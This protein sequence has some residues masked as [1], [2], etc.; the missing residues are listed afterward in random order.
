[1][2]HN[3]RCHRPSRTN[4]V[5][6]LYHAGLA[7]TVVLVLV[8]VFSGSAAALDINDTDSLDYWS[9]TTLDFRVETD[10]TIRAQNILDMNGNDI[11]GAGVVEGATR[12]QL[13]G[14][15]NIVSDGSFETGGMSYWTNTGSISTSQVLNGSYSL[16]IPSKSSGNSHNDVYQERPDGAAQ[17]I[18]VKPGET[19]A[20]QGYVYSTAGA[21]AADIGIR[22]YDGSRS[23]VTWTGVTSNSETGSW[24]FTRGYWTVPSGSQYARI[25][26]R[27]DD[28]NTG[29]ENYFDNIRV[30]RVDKP[31]LEMTGKIDMNS[32]KITNLQDP[33]NVQDAATKSYVDNN[34]DT[35]SD[36]QGH[37]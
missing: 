27:G 17:L 15:Q 31:R 35:G 8:T 30:Y 29:G 2:R 14:E 33:N 28:Q 24:E 20:V 13:S 1:M 16:N 10:G 5:F 34:D 23:H 4:K 19:Y 12:G 9:D 11:V 32:N 6:R 7:F 21:D 3:D 18:K 37:C 36:S 26:L 25:W 22:E